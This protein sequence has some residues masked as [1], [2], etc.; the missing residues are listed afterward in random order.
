MSHETMVT[1][2]DGAALRTWTSGSA[3]PDRLPI[4]LIHGGPGV[5]DYLGAVAADLE[6]QWLVHRYDQRGVGGSSWD[7]V[8]TLA[9][10]VQ[11]AISLLD[12]WGHEK[13]TLIG[14]SFGTNLASY[15]TLAHPERVAVLVQLA[16]PF[17][18]PRW[19]RAEVDAARARR[20]TAQQDRL[21]ELQVRAHRTEDEEIEMLTLAGFPNHVDP[22]CAWEWAAEAARTQRPINWV[23]N[24]QL[25]AAK[26][27][28][29]LEDR[30]DDLRS[31]MPRG[32]VFIGGTGDPR[33]E[34]ELRALAEKLGVTP[35][36]IPD[37]GHAP[38]LEQ[39]RTFREA[40]RTAVREQDTNHRVLLTGF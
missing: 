37:A 36:M 25:N 39:P 16:G 15:I 8:Y 10:A 40:L 4:L 18:G 31:M 28:I 23:M 9:Q 14:P 5:P 3:S 24:S 38:W 32:A 11:D 30:I 6:D 12:H 2:P 17:L 20:T 35:V 33:P 22:E 26:R 21:E 1:M 13:A 27:A 29:P 19:S 7:G 34:T